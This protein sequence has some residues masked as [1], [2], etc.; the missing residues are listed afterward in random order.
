M[1][2]NRFR[3][4]RLFVFCAL[5]GVAVFLAAC[6]DI[7]NDPNTSNMVRSLDVHVVQLDKVDSTSLKLNPNFP[8][9]LNAVV[10]PSSR[11]S[12]LSFL[13]YYDSLLIDTGATYTVDTSDVFL[14]NALVAM[15]QRGNKLSKN[16]EITVNTPPILAK[17][18]KPADGD[19]LYAKSTTPI[20]FR[21]FSADPDVDDILEHTLIIDGISYSIGP[22]TSI[23]QSG[24]KPGSHTFKVKVVDSHGDADSLA[25]RTFY[26]TNGQGSK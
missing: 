1:N 26:V 3:I 23:S 12:E 17:Q 14:P 24:F 11:K 15:D 4:L 6:L 25:S 10:H 13:W 21:W 7:P 9:E 2:L 18:T 5:W 22:L 19:T 16:F 20:T 8:A